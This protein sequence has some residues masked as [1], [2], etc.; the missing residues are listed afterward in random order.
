MRTRLG[1]TVQHFA[2]QF[3][4]VVAVEAAS[5]QAGIGLRYRLFGIE[6]ALGKTI[7]AAEIPDQATV[8]LEAF[9]DLADAIHLHAVARAKG[10][11]QQGRTADRV[12][13]QHARAREYDLD[14]AT[15]KPQHGAEAEFGFGATEPA[16]SG[17]EF[18]H[19]SASQNF[20]P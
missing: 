7:G 16:L 13:A 3:E 17:S 12:V 15:G 19:V 5:Q 20:H 6:F 1:T 8:H 2:A 10:G 18:E 14:L 4:A 9:D 11:A